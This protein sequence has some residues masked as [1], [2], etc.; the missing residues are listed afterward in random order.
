M[1]LKLRDKVVL[2]SGASRGIGKACLDLL[3]EE[4]AFVIAIARDASGIKQD[5][6][7]LPLNIDVSKKEEI[8]NLFQI[9]QARFNNLD[10]LVNNVGSNIRKGTLDY[11]E[12]DFQT[13]FNTNLKSAYEL[14]R[15]FIKMANPGASIINISSVASERRIK[16]STLVYS[17]SKAAMNEMT[18]NMASE[19]GPQNIRVNAILPWYI[20]TELVKE[21]LSDKQ[22]LDAILELTPLR[23]VGQPED[24]ANLVG[25]LASEKSAYISGA[26]IPVDGAMLC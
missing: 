1:D 7:T 5:D 11:E 3:R 6:Q 15:A 19:F 12:D 16:T 13:I 2:L 10:V 9:I 14:S 24:V 25:F 4:G 20:E 21:V 26:L 18:K 23:R 17:I 22:K 8:E